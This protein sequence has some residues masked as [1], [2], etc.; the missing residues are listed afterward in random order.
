MGDRRTWPFCG[1][2]VSLAQATAIR[3]FGSLPRFLREGT[4]RRVVRGAL[5]AMS[6]LFNDDLK[7]TLPVPRASLRRC[8]SA[9]IPYL[10]DP[11]FAGIVLGLLLDADGAYRIEEIQGFLPAALTADSWSVRTTAYLVAQRH[12]ENLDSR[13]VEYLK[14]CLD[15][16]KKVRRP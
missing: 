12:S 10:E 4:D 1:A 9:S 3:T 8:V 14:I 13:V 16:R 2:L 7:P 15:E 5:L 6:T 11:E